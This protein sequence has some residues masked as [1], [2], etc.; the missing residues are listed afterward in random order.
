MLGWLFCSIGNMACYT[1]SGTVGPVGNTCWWVNFTN[2]QRYIFLSDYSCLDDSSAAMEIMHIPMIILVSTLAW[3]PLQTQLQTP[4]RYDFWRP[5]CR[6]PECIPLLTSIKPSWRL[7]S[8]GLP[9]LGLPLRYDFRSCHHDIHVCFRLLT[10]IQPSWRL[11]SLGLP[12]RYD[13][14][15]CHHFIHVWFRLL[16]SMKPSWRLLLCCPP[17]HPHRYEFG[18]VH[19]IFHACLFLILSKLTQMLPLHC[20]LM[21]QCLLPRALLST[22]RLP[23]MPRISKWCNFTAGSH[24]EV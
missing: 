7:P 1:L 12:L 15:S 11:P 10:S 13:F 22:Q 20:P 21:Q 24:E 17:H 23:K 18:S 2:D 9:S 19:C 8:L 5:H 16:T 6:I 14:C 4:Q 3:S